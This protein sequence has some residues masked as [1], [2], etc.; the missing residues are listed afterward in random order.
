[1]ERFELKNV[2]LK[3]QEGDAD[4]KMEGEDEN[5]TH[6]SGNVLDF[7]YTNMTLLPDSFTIQRPTTSDHY[8]I[9]CSLSFTRD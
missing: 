2:D 9:S 3:F 8:S 4:A 5:A 7:I 6:T 1:M